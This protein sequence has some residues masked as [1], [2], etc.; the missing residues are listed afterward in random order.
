MV[1]TNPKTINPKVIDLLVVSSLIFITS[2]DLTKIPTK[3]HMIPIISNGVL[4]W[5][6]PFSF[7]QTLSTQTKPFSQSNLFSHFSFSLDCAQNPLTHDLLKHSE[8]VLQ[9]SFA[10]FGLFESVRIIDNRKNPI[11][12]AAK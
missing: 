12:I 7:I 6:N 10:F 8:F 4:N 9:I 3:K 5:Q 2:F 1:T 11:T